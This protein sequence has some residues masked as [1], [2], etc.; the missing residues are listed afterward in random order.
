MKIKSLFILTI[1]FFGVL[2]LAILLSVLITGQQV[3]QIGA[4]E[5]LAVQ[6][7]REAS[8]LSYL[9]TEYVLYP[10]DQQQSR[11]ET[12]FDV[13]TAELAGLQLTEPEAVTLQNNLRDTSA[14]LHV[15]FADV[16]TTFKS[17]PASPNPSFIAV[18]WSRMEVQNQS[19]VFDAARLANLLNEESDRLKQTNLVL[20]LVLVGLLGA[21]FL[22]NYYLISR[23]VLH[24]IARLQ[25]GTQTIGAGNLDSPIPVLRRDEIGALTLSF[26]RM[27]EDL[28]HVMAKKADLEREMAD[29]KQAE[30]SLRQ[31]LERIQSLNRELQ[32]TNNELE[33]FVYTV[34]HDL[35]A[36]LQQ[37]AELSR[38]ILEDDEPE[39]PAETRSIVRLIHDHA[40]ATNCL[41]NDLL[42]LS[43]ITHVNPARQTVHM[44]ELVREVVREVNT[45]E[46]ER[47]V[48]I[49]VGDLPDAEADP[50]LLKQVWVNLISNALKFTR[51]RDVA[52]I[53]VGSG[54][55]TVD[56]NELV[57]EPDSSA[58]PDI[59]H[60][61]LETVYFVQDNGAGFDMAQVDRLFRAFHRLHHGDEFEGNGLGL[62]IVQRIVERHGG[63]AWAQGAVDQ[64]A[65]FYFTL[66]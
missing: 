46:D 9:S 47:Q 19:L 61:S 26:N 4:Q 6:L 35:R 18:V 37:M 30:E 56:T 57:S 13:F 8:E 28:K 34:A 3:E 62:S 10:D 31:A 66:G 29:R 51:G 41:A 11:W 32:A 7:E 40:A 21:Y 63:R 20:V 48:E 15:I 33:A 1:G 44:L 2:L 45:A 14:R 25:T 58:G 49:R 27:A 5:D 54:K 55:W 59:D 22:V 64:G 65:T 17:A 23:R 42:T 39:L 38:A 43:R 24:S 16:V 50:R 53:E 36:P 60:Y 52:K 12:K